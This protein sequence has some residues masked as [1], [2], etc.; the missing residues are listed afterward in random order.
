MK[1]RHNVVKEMWIDGE[2]NDVEARVRRS[3]KQAL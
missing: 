2:K 3:V 1:H